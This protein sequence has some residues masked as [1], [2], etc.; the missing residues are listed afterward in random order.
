MIYRRV[1][2]ERERHPAFRIFSDNMT[3]IEFETY[4]AEQ[5]RR[6]GWNDHVTKQSRDQGVDV[7][8]EKNWCSRCASVQ[9]LFEASWE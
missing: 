9:A 4:C 2:A 3:A 5:L 6:A 1:E 8:A 7:V